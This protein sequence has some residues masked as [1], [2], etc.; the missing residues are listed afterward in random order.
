M[1]TRTILMQVFVG[2]PKIISPEIVGLCH[3]VAPGAVP[4][5]VPVKPDPTAEI[6]ECFFN[7]RAK[8]ERDGGQLLNGWAVHEWPRVFIEAEHHAVWSMAGELLDVTP[9]VPPV[10]QVLFLPDGGAE[11]DYAG[12]KPRWNIRRPLSS[13]S[14]VR[15]YVAVADELDRF[16]ERHSVGRQRV[17]TGE[18]IAQLKDF[19]RRLAFLKLEIIMWLDRNTGRNDRCICGSA[20]KYKNC[21]KPLVP[22]YAGGGS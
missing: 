7:V 21:C 13:E 9:H 17:F 14:C 18:A 11:F 8:V 22:P 5:F 3:H 1:D 19:G 4:V 20:R 10:S 15:E 16:N 6:S 12:L 2:T